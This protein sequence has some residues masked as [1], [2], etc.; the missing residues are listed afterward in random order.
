[1]SDSDIYNQEILNIWKTHFWSQPETF[2]NPLLQLNPLLI[3]TDPPRNSII[4]LGINPSHSEKVLSSM[5]TGDELKL[6]YEPVSSIEQLEA[7]R[8]KQIQI[9]M[10]KELKYFAQI[11]KF[12]AESCDIDREACWFLD[13]FPIRHTAQHEAINFLNQNPVIRDQLLQSFIKLISA[14][15]PLG[16]IVLNATGSKLF[17]EIFVD[18]LRYETGRKSEGRL[19]LNSLTIP[20]V[21]SGM[22]TGLGQMDSFSKERLA[23]DL[24]ALFAKNI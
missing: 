11:K 22:V 6:F 5:L 9:R 24:K 17:A 2:W 23:N 12:L 1:M 10:H 19:M 4:I 8:L 21:F 15:N 3:P 14:I 18:Q 16:V 13:L 20:V 7:N